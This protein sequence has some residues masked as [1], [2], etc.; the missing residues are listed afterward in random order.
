M[1]LEDF[2]DFKILL[3]QFLSYKKSDFRDCLMKIKQEGPLV[4]NAIY[5]NQTEFLFIMVIQDINNIDVSERKCNIEFYYKAFDI[6][7]QLPLFIYSVIKSHLM[8]TI[9]SKFMVME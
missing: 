5:E 9:L 8:A 1:T 2:F 6:T 4:D 3:P 7:I